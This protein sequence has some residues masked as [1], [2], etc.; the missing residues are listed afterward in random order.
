MC[1]PWLRRTRHVASGDERERWWLLAH[2]AAEPFRPTLRG[3]VRH[4]RGRA[5]RHLADECFVE[6]FCPVRRT[7]MAVAFCGTIRRDRISSVRLLTGNLLKLLDIFGYGVEPL[8]EP[9]RLKLGDLL[10][11]EKRKVYMLTLTTEPGSP[12]F[13]LQIARP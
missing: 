10:P 2:R 9:R 4:T 6:A 5:C 1:P 8:A 7:R 11:S 13:I 12:C 3:F